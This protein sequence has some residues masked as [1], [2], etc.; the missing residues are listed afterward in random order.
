MGIRKGGYFYT[1]ATKENMAPI[2]ITELHSYLENMNWN[3][4]ITI[5]IAGFYN[6]KYSGYNLC[7]SKEIVN[8]NIMKI[9]NVVSNSE[10]KVDIKINLRRKEIQEKKNVDMYTFTEQ[11]LS[12]N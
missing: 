12:S 3:D 10:K 8:N 1:I 6:L 9:R 5:Q 11:W 2:Q 7:C 4:C